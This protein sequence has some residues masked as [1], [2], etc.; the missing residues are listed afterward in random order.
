MRVLL[1]QVQ[2]IQ[3]GLAAEPAAATVPD[4]SGT[5]SDERI[6][7][8][9][10][11]LRMTLGSFSIDS[12]EDSVRNEGVLVASVH[13]AKGLEWVW[14]RSLLGTNFFGTGF[15]FPCL[16]ER[17]RLADRVCCGT[18]SLT[19][20]CFVCCEACVLP[21]C[22]ARNSVTSRKSVESAT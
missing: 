11:V 12:H 2:A 15:C 4:S 19:I 3:A 9:L 7:M 1:E 8:G 18:S 22:R 17:R 5:A 20:D 6:P 10:T 13:Q 16:H 14:Q 21:P